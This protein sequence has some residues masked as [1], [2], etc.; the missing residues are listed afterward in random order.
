MAAQGD[1]SPVL[2]IDLGHPLTFNRLMLQEMI[3][4]G[5]R[6]ESFTLEAWHAGEWKPVVRGTTIGHKRLERF[7][8]ITTDR[9]RLVIEKSRACPALRSLGLYQAALGT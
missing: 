2:T 9:V 5:Q 7:G 6:I 8:Q 4:E 3:T 1:S